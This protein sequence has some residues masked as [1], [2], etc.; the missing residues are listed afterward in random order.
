MGLRHSIKCPKD[1]GFVVGDI[2]IAGQPIKYGGQLAELMLIQLTGQA[3]RLNS[4]NDL[5]FVDCKGNFTSK[6]KL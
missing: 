4:T 2:T 3:V 1:W 6:T 5:I